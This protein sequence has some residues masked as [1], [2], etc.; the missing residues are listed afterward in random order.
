MHLTGL[1]L[2]RTELRG[3]LWLQIRGREITGVWKREVCYMSSPGKVSGEQRQMK[4][5][6]HESMHFCI[7][8]GEQIQRVSFLFFFFPF[9]YPRFSF[10]FF[11]LFLFSF[12]IFVFFKFYPFTRFFLVLEKKQNYTYWDRGML[13]EFPVRSRAEPQTKWN[14]MHCCLKLRSGGNTFNYF[15]ENWTID[16]TDG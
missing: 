12:F 10:L 5:F 7:G 1:L 8:V 13:W 2:K 14:L 3:Y 9:S 16:H 4:L 11:S 15:P 6:V